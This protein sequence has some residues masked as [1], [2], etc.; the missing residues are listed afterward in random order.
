MASTLAGGA[1]W[2]ELKLA[3][4]HTHWHPHLHVLHE[5]RYIEQ[6]WLATDWHRITG[7][8][9]IVDVRN[10]KGHRDVVRYVTSYA[11]KPLG[12]ALTHHRSMLIEALADMT[13]RR[14][15][16]T[17]GS[18]RGLKL[19][20]HS[21]AIDWQ[22][23]APLAELLIRAAAGDPWADNLLSNLRGRQPW[24]HK[25]RPNRSPRPP[26]PPCASLFQPAA[27]PSAP[28]VATA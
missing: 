8:S 17:F 15:M 21:P 26:P 10:I 14:L 3:S 18:W 4:D 28:A 2:L 20:A 27:R 22:P 5:G 1:A 6:G 19:C 25:R 12:L 7:D 11:S 23:I 9:Y 13:A 24:N 16:T